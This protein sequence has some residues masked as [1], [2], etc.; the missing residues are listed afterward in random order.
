MA[1]RGKWGRRGRRGRRAH[2][3]GGAEGSAACPGRWLAR[4]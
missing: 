4:P 3:H 2:G 1:D